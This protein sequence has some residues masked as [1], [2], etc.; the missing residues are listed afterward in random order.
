MVVE[1]MRIEPCKKCK[2][3]K[4]LHYLSTLCIDCF[5]LEMKEIRKEHIEKS[6]EEYYD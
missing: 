4:E 2:E 3:M 5:N 6:G 1:L